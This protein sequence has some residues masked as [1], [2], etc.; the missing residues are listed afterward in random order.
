SSQI[1]HVQ[2]EERKRISRELHD[3]VG[4]ALTAINTNLAIL[5]RGGTT[6]V[7]LFNKRIADAQQ[8]LR[9]TLEIVHGFA[10]ELRPAMLDELG[11]LPALRSFLRAFAERTGLDVR[12][13]RNADAEKLEPEQKTVLFRIAQ[14]S[15]TNVV[16]HAQASQVIVTVRRVGRRIQLQVKDNGKA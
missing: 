1:L 6:D 4:Q 7:A 11:L 10:R 5:Q 16:K 14:E 2:E 9:Q 8:L 13:Y 3:Q 15:L 12:F